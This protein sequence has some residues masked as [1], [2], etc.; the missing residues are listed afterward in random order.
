MASGRLVVMSIS[1]TVAAPEPSSFSTAMPARV[2]SSARRASS[3]LISTKSRSHWGESFIAQCLCEL[4]EESDIA[5]EEHL[6]V[7]DAVLHH[8]QSLDAHSERESC[9]L[10]WVVAV[11]FDQP[12]DVGIDHA[13]AHEFHP[14]AVVAGAA[15]FAAADDA[16][17]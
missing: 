15:A 2:R 16:A 7:V 13:A 11:I 8:R 4:F 6:N 1:K 14:A 9:N 17:D 5:L 12:E 3:A 10:G